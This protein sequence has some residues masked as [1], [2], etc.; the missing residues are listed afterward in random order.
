MHRH[1]WH[2]D[3][4]AKEEREREREGNVDVYYFESVVI[5]K[6]AEREKSRRNERRKAER[7]WNNSRSRVAF[8]FL[9]KRNFNARKGARGR[10]RERE[11][12]HRA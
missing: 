10:E 8:S 9:V 7:R 11:T 3:T 4:D 2:R 12:D 5:A 6:T 1:A